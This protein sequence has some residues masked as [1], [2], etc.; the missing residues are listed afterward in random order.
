MCFSLKALLHCVV[1]KE[2][3]EKYKKLNNLS[4]VKYYYTK[5]YKF[6]K[7]RSS[8]KTCVKSVLLNTVQ[9]LW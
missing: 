1:D 3:N 8:Y 6:I 9:I 2:Q 5:I 4:S 7:E